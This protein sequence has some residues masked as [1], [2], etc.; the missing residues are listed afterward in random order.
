ML[1]HLIFSKNFKTS[2]ENGEWKVKEETI[3]FADEVAFR[4]SYYQLTSKF[5]EKTSFEK[6]TENKEP[7]LNP[8]DDSS[9]KKDDFESIHLIDNSIVN[10]K[11][12]DELVHV[13]TSQQTV[14][15][16]PKSMADLLDR[17]NDFQTVSSNQS[18][19]PL[20][21]YW[22]GLSKFVLL[23]PIREN[24]YIDSESRAK[25]ILSSISI[26]INNTGR[27]HI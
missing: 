3:Q 7:Y 17:T 13:T 23:T 14:N 27:Y 21:A 9:S 15:L 25:V 24:S 4:F 22:F 2:F 20:L 8:V 10:K 1:G 26:A 16:P 19:T 6:N 12:E 5:N 18:A 11:C